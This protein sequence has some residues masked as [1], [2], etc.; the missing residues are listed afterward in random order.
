MWLKKREFRTGYWLYVGLLCFTTPACE[1]AIVMYR[2]RV[3]KDL[4]LVSVYL[5]GKHGS[6]VRTHNVYIYLIMYKGNWSTRYRW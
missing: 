1:F 4:T 6:C 3:Q 2:F 5:I